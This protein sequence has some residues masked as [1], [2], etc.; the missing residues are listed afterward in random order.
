MK[1][2]NRMAYFDET[3]KVWNG[4]KVDRSEL[5]SL[6]FRK[7]LL[8]SFRTTP[9]K[10]FQISDDERTQLTYKETESLSFRI[11]ENLKR[12][13]IHQ[14]D[15][16][17]LMML[18]STYVAPFAFGCILNGVAVSPF[19]I[20]QGITFEEIKYRL[21]ISKPRAII[22]EEFVNLTG[23][24]LQVIKEMELDCKIFTIGTDTKLSKPNVFSFC[25]LLNENKVEQKFE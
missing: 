18:N 25:E 21:N 6:T 11:A 10:I 8:R 13:G 2:R 14:G 5:N 17:C 15:V 1:I 23:M 19:L 24:I 22:L 12:F 20:S 9:D 16:V 3:S 4:P 7:H